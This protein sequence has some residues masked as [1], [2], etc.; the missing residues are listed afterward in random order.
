L[1]TQHVAATY[2]GLVRAGMWRLSNNARTDG[3]AMS[4]CW[5]TN[6]TS[7]H[8]FFNTD[9]LTSSEPVVIVAI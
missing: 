7:S 3:R 5:R 6:T 4:E 2:R 1:V 9:Q 8:A